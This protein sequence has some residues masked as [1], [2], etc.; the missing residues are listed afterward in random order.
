MVKTSELEPEVKLVVKYGLVHEVCVIGWGV[1]RRNHVY[2]EAIR[3]TS[4]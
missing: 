3:P 4:S 1:T 2:K